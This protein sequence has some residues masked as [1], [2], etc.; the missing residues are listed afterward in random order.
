MEILLARL[1]ITLS[2]LLIT[3]HAFAHHAFV[4][5][6]RLT[7]SQLI[8]EEAF[9]NDKRILTR[10]RVDNHKQI[11]AIRDFVKSTLDSIQSRA[12]WNRAK[13]D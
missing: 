5:Q 4:V 9:S 13:V 3:D 6:A 10:M 2:K 11:I 7:E 12:N 1:L 8:T